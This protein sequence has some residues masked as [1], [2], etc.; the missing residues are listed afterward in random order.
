MEQ[1]C[2]G[3]AS[4]LF[5]FLSFPHKAFRKAIV[6]ISVFGVGFPCP[7]LHACSFLH[8]VFVL[9]LS[10]SFVVQF[11]Y[12]LSNSVRFFKTF[13]MSLLS[14]SKYSSACRASIEPFFEFPF[15]CIER[16]TIKLKGWPLGPQFA[17]GHALY[18]LIFL[19]KWYYLLSLCSVCILLFTTFL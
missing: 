16:F 19:G 13:F 15:F 12:Y 6:V 17:R 3:F 2:R 4:N 5:T 1:F 10:F 11:E 7:L 18:Q 8:N 14:I 9:Q